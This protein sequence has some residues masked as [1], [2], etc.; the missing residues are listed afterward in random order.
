MFNVTALLNRFCLSFNDVM[1]VTAC[2]FHSTLTS[3]H[4]I[5]VMLIII[6]R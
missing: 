6:E 3:L 4:D 2:T 5:T 1:F